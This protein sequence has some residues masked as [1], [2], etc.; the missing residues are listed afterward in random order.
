MAELIDWAV[1]APN[2]GYTP[3]KYN[4]PRYIAFFNCDHDNIIW[5]LDALVYVFLSL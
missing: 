2:S 1:T 5:P 3:R 4:T